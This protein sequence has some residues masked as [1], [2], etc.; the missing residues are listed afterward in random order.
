VDP[1]DIQ[2]VSIVGKAV[3][4]AVT[5]ASEEMLQAY[6]LAKH[7]DCSAHLAGSIVREL[8]HSGFRL[9]DPNSQPF[10]PD[11]WDNLPGRLALQDYVKMA[12]DLT[13]AG[14]RSILKSY[15]RRS[16]AKAIDQITETI[17]NSFRVNKVVLERKRPPDYRG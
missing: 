7:P 1:K 15:D 17:C 8:H 9:K 11:E 16:Q 12:L 2:R 6:F 13:D 3:A 5:M 14:T 4:R 10:R